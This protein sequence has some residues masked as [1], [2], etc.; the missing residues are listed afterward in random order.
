MDETLNGLARVPTEMVVEPRLGYGIPV[1]EAPSAIPSS[2]K[3][4]RLEHFALG[5]GRGAERLRYQPGGDS[6][7]AG[8]DAA[9]FLAASDV[10]GDLRFDPSG[11]RP[12]GIVV[13]RVLDAGQRLPQ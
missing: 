1:A 11:Q 2:K 5:C 4:D 6:V 3:A 8:P 7:R 9:E 12:D 10:S 13:P